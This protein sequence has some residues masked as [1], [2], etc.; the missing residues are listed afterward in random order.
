[1]SRVEITHGN[2]IR[3]TAEARLTPTGRPP[4]STAARLAEIP[5]RHGRTRRAR[6]R[7]KAGT[8]SRQAIAT[9][10]LQADAHKRALATAVLAEETPVTGDRARVQATWVRI[11]VGEAAEIVWATVALQV[12][13][14]DLVVPAPSEAAPE[15]AHEPAAPA[16]LPAWAVRA[17]AVRAG[18]AAAGAGE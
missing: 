14:E 6:T 10:V 12:A 15:V 5:C 8:G 7:D 17:A 2:T 13:V 3:S 1:M 16:G 11:A 9:A 4:I 18:A